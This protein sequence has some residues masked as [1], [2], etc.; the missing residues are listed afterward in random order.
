MGKTFSGKLCPD[1][2]IQS[3]GVFRKTS[4]WTELGVYS[5]RVTI[6]YPLLRGLCGKGLLAVVWG[7]W[8][9]A[10]IIFYFTLINAYKNSTEMSNIKDELSI[11]NSFSPSPHRQIVRCQVCIICRYLPLY[12]SAWLWVDASLLDF[13]Y[14]S[15]CSEFWGISSTVF[16]VFGIFLLCNIPFLFY[17]YK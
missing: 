3:N 11:G 10:K 9:R 7:E 2:L 8:V 4:L 6:F 17:G 14:L 12:L 15:L 16:N 5:Q 13:L 1:A